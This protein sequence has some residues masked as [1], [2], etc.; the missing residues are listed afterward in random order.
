MTQSLEAA[1]VRNRLEEKLLVRGQRGLATC[2]KDLLSTQKA[3][4]VMMS[5]LAGE[6][7]QSLHLLKLAPGGAD[8]EGEG[9]SSEA[10]Y[11]NDSQYAEFC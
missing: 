3:L 11:A 4:G 10:S 1:G 8:A 7:N 2:S 9:T 6:R 5:T